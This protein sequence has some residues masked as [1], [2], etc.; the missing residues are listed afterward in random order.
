MFPSPLLGGFV[1]LAPAAD[2]E[3]AQC[4]LWLSTRRT[5]FKHLQV[6]D[7]RGEEFGAG[8]FTYWW[9]PPKTSNGA[10]VKRGCQFSYKIIKN[11][12]FTL[13]RKW[14]YGIIN[15]YQLVRTLNCKDKLDA[16]LH[17]VQEQC[18]RPLCYTGNSNQ[19]QFSWNQD[20]S[21]IHIPYIYTH[22]CVP[23]LWRASYYF[24]RDFEVSNTFMF[25]LD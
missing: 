1:P 6:F 22:P 20:T 5:R 11:L 23:P 18:F 8:A 2:A 17:K 7:R 3:Q 24:R 16:L 10:T 15:L 9:I 21:Q 14:N 12:E 19:Q 13:M 25:F 4:V